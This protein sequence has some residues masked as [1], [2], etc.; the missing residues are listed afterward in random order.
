MT[1]RHALLPV[2]GAAGGLRSPAACKLRMPIRG[3]VALKSGSKGKT[4]T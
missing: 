3:H 4:G 1:A 2:S